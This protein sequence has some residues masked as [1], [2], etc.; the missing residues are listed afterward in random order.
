MDLSS[1][2][3]PLQ[4]AVAAVVAAGATFESERI[5]LP[6]P[7]L[8]LPGAVAILK[9]LVEPLTCPSC[10]S[11]KVIRHGMRERKG[12][13]VQQYKCTADSHT[14]NRFFNE[15]T[16]LPLEGKSV[17]FFQWMA[18]RGCHWALENQPRM[19]ASKPAS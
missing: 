8:E 4:P 3:E 16:G 11:R 1:L 9:C 19:G 5:V 15:Y 6:F 14:G 7:A 13:L 18:L 17:L 12:R 2:P 10:S